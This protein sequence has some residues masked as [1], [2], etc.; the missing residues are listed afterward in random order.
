MTESQPTTALES[1]MTDILQEIKT[2]E[3][4]RYFVKSILASKKFDGIL[5]PFIWKLILILC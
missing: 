4:F 1:L 3:M 2:E 5:N